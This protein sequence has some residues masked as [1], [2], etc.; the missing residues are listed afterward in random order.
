MGEIILL[1]ST[2]TCPVCGHQKEETMPVDARQYFY[3]VRNA[4]LC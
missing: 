4:G 2:I 1:Q 3:H